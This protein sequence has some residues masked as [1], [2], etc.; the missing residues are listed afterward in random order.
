M[1]GMFK[2]R[3]MRSFYWDAAASNLGSREDN[4]AASKENRCARLVDSSRN[5]AVRTASGLDTPASRFD[6]TA[7]GPDA[8]DGVLDASAI[9]RD[10]GGSGDISPGIGF[11]LTDSIDITPVNGSG[12]SARGFN[13][14]L[15]GLNGRGE[16][17]D[18]R[19][20]G[21]RF[22]GNETGRGSGEYGIWKRGT[23]PKS[24]ATGRAGGKVCR[25]LREEEAHGH[26][27]RGHHPKAANPVQQAETDGVGAVDGGK[28]G[29]KGRLG[30]D[31]G[32]IVQRLH[33]ILHPLDA[34]G[35]P[36]TQWR[37]NLF[38]A[39][40]RGGLRLLNEAG[41]EADGD[42][43]DFAGDLVVAVFEADGFGL[44]AAFEHL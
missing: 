30:C 5:G 38:S 2:N 6:G 25:L 44:G 20:Y 21:E 39:P 24:W 17:G 34:E 16:S 22:L 3:E 10:F 19:T 14:E 42:A 13:N 1:G 18:Q 37:L 15:S 8:V 12:R 4:L 9:G 33:N 40:G 11:D 29:A 23:L 41:F 43:I 35:V 36:A 27:H 26:H 31:R 28:R 7:R 32:V